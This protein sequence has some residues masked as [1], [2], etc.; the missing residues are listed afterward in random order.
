MLAQREN[1][2]VD[3]HHKVHILESRKRRFLRDRWASSNNKI[4]DRRLHNALIVRHMYV[5]SFVT[6]T[7]VWQRFRQRVRELHERMK[8]GARGRTDNTSVLLVSLYVRIPACIR[9]TQRRDS[10]YVRRGWKT[11]RR[12]RSFKCSS[13]GL[14]KHIGSDVNA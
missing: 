11:S 2:T 7:C 6:R 3:Q 12:A 9:S 1:C 10:Q 13:R 5:R 4:F 14:T 8:W